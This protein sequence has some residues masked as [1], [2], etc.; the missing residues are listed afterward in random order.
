M[1]ST[2]THNTPGNYCLQQ[3][4]YQ[5]KKSLF[6]KARIKILYYLNSDSDYY[7]KMKEKTK[8]KYNL[9]KVNGRWV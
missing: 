6:E 2:R 8:E 4:E 3:R 5:D 1:A 7:T 9:K